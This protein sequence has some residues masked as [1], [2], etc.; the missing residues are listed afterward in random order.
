MRR[1]V[2]AIT[3]GV[4]MAVTLAVPAEAATYWRLQVG[5]NGRCLGIAGGWPQAGTPAVLWDCNSNSDQYWR[6]GNAWPTGG[7]WYELRNR[8]DPSMCLGVSGGAWEPRARLVSWPCNGHPDQFWN[9]YDPVNTPRWTSYLRVR[10]LHSLYYITT[11]GGAN[12]DPIVQDWWDE[13]TYQFWR[14]VA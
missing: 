3:V 4:M 8:S 11:T 1:V 12:G 9:W 13:S 5:F 14:W 2:A 6:V 7:G 10:N